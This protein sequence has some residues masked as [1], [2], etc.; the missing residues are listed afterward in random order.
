MS[1]DITKNLPFASS[2]GSHWRRPAA[3]ETAAANAHNPTA[4]ETQRKTECRTR[5]VLCISLSILLPAE[6]SGA[7]LAGCGRHELRAASSRGPQELRRRGRDAPLSRP[8][9]TAAGVQAPAAWNLCAD[10]ST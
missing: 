5:N 4:R 10:S 2:D 7:G 1:S 9:D 8:K 3:P 6:G